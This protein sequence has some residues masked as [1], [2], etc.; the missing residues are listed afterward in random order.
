MMNVVVSFNADE[1]K[2]DG[3]ERTVVSEDLLCLL[4][5][6]IHSFLRWNK[7]HQLFELS[8]ATV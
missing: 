5:C 2:E 7:A 4:A 3:D 1:C 8:P 6:W